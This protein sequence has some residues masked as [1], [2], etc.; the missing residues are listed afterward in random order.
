MAGVEVSLQPN[1]K[2]VWP[3]SFHLVALVAIAP[4]VTV[5]WEMYHQGQMH[6]PTKAVRSARHTLVG[7][8]SA[9]RP[10]PAWKPNVRNQTQPTRA[11]QSLQSARVSDDIANGAS[12]NP[13]IS[14]PGSK[15]YIQ[16]LPKV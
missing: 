1:T 16:G 3:D 13:N 15:V 4:P 7:P 11:A 9:G 2:P 8:G 10:L 14:E 5:L 12:H 6:R